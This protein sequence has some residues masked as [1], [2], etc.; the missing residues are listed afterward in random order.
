MKL[1]YLE[2][3]LMIMRCQ[4][5][6]KAAEKLYISQPSLSEAVKKM[7]EKLGFVVF[8]RNNKGIE[9]TPAGEKFLADAQEI[10][11]ISSRW[12][13]YGAEQMPLN[14]DE[15][16]GEVNLVLTPSICD[17]FLASA[18]PKIHSTYRNLSINLHQMP[19]EDVCRFLIQYNISLGMFSIET[20]RVDEFVKIYE[21]NGYQCDFIYSDEFRI[22]VSAEDSL[23]SREEISLAEL[24]DYT[25]LMIGEKN[26][27]VVKTIFA[28]YFEKQCVLPKLDSVMTVL[29][30]P[31]NVAIFVSRAI[32][33]SSWMK[34]GK[35]VMLP[36]REST[37]QIENYLVH[38]SDDVLSVEE[39]IVVDTILEENS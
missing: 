5:I 8:K 6:S 38:R 28:P 25:L 15:V 12:K 1:R 11:N 9:I 2:Y 34:N 14:N 32:K 13:N 22:F 7:K 26:S 24:K 29:S 10:L 18:F 21:H 30:H 3:A 23:A 19:T 17:V 4:S 27:S 20:V 37:V 31:G 39:R 35:I 36:F 16:R 33:A